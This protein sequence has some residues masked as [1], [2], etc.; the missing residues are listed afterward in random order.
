MD[1]LYPDDCEDD[2]DDDDDDIHIMMKCL[3]VCHEKFKHFFE[4]E[5]GTL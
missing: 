2:D 1:Q 3:F 5:L 4:V